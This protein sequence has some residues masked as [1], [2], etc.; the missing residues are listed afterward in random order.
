[1]RGSPLRLPTTALRTPSPATLFFSVW[2]SGAGFLG[3]G[4]HAGSLPDVYLASRR[5]SSGSI[6]QIDEIASN[7]DDNAP[8]FKFLGKPV[9]WLD[10]GD[11]TYT[12]IGQ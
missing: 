6:L 2:Y 9:S 12:L 8:P 10:N 11:G 5:P 3:M 4:E 1:M 7:D